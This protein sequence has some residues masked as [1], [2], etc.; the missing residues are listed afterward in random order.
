MKTAFVTAKAP[1]DTLA[2]EKRS[3][4]M[5]QLAIVAAALLLAFSIAV[6]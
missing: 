3:S 1:A 2:I 5:Y 4:T 6:L